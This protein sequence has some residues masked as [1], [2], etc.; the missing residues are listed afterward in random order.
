MDRRLGGSQSKSRP[1]Q[2]RENSWL[3]RTSNS[4]PSV[5]QPV[6]SRC[7]DYDFP[8]PV[9]DIPVICVLKKN[10]ASEIFF[11]KVSMKI[12]LCVAVS[13]VSVE[14]TRLHET[15]SNFDIK[16]KFP[17]I[18]NEIKS[19]DS[20]CCPFVY[21]WTQL[22]GARRPTHFRLQGISI[23]NHL[24]LWSNELLMEGFFSASNSACAVMFDQRLW[25]PYLN[26]I[27]QNIS[28]E[29]TSC[30]DSADINGTWYPKIAVLT[31]GHHCS[32]SSAW[33]VF[34]IYSHIFLPIDIS[35]THGAEPF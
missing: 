32:F 4:D 21:A 34:K 27:E 9:R 10:L 7:T 6:T 17:W 23:F 20:F 16:F 35:L 5:V 15:W 30:S 3:W 26:S 25:L 18:R 8:A 29:D 1:P 11:S 12:Y 19:I 33:R 22:S 31:T 2:R 28:W 14:R 24:L 13:T